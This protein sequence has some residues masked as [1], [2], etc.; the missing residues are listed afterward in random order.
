MIPTNLP[1]LKGAS[2]VGV[3]WGRFTQ[4]EPERHRAN[5]S[6][7]V[8]WASDGTIDPIIQRKYSLDDG[9]EALRWVAERRAIGRIVV[10]P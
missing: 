8:E 3:F 4:E 6:R 10:N 1:L 9:A 2:L 5:F 7:I